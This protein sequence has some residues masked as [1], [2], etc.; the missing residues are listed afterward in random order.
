MPMIKIDGKDYDTDKLSE[1]AKQQLSALQVVD[2]EI[3]HIQI[4]LSI[5]QTA[6][7]VHL[8]L[9][10]TALADPMAGDAIKLG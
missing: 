8:Q 4:Q 7:N 5:A 2:N 6:R 10:K 9:L 1:Q 3:R